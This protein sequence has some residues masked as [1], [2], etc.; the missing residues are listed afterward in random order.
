MS[1]C[2]V[3]VRYR[4]SG[5]LFLFPTVSVLVHA[6]AIVAPCKL[7]RLEWTYEENQ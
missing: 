6:P 4:R 7:L 1:V 5:S 3:R 2:F